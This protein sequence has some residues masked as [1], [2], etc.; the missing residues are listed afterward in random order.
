[1]CRQRF[2]QLRPWRTENWNEETWREHWFPVAPNRLYTPSCH[3]RPCSPLCLHP[4]F[5][6]SPNT[7][8]KDLCASIVRWTRKSAYWRM[9]LPW[10]EWPL[11]KRLAPTSATG[12]VKQTHCN[13]LQIG[14]HRRPLPVV[15]RC[16]S[17]THQT[18]WSAWTPYGWAQQPPSLWLNNGHALAMELLLAAG[19][20]SLCWQVNN[21]SFCWE[22]V[23]LQ[24]HQSMKLFL[25]GH[26][27]VSSPSRKFTIP[28]K[29]C[30]LFLQ[31]ANPT[32]RENW[33]VTPTSTCNT[34]SAIPWDVAV[35]RRQRRRGCHGPVST[36]TSGAVDEVKQVPASNAVFNKKHGPFPAHCGSRNLF[37]FIQFFFILWINYRVEGMYI[38]VGLLNVLLYSLNYGD[39]E[40]RVSAARTF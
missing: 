28:W 16:W 22:H 33:Y 11:L 35:R 14:H 3:H 34:K 13:Q 12:P 29:F 27:G 10:D 18:R 1:M 21:E 4:I 9:R 15:P 24:P 20:F 26:V 38:Y 8:Y 31:R 6:T 30:M 7:L 25:K 32:W 36:T 23:N 19:E 39:N 37:E 40:H 2:G 5:W 17:C